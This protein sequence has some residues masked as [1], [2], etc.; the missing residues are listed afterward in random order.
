L[1]NDSAR[2][3]SPE[4]RSLLN[5]LKKFNFF[6]PEWYLAHNMDVLSIGEDPWVHFV[7]YGVSEHRQPNP[8]FDPIWYLEFYDD[9]RNAGVNPLLHYLWNGLHEGR[10]PSN[11]ADPLFNVKNI[12]LLAVEH[13]TNTCQYCSTSSPFSRKLSHSASSF[14]PWLDMLESERIPFIYISITGGEPFLHHDIGAFIYELKGRYPF[15]K[16]GVTTNFYWANE[17]KIRLFAPIIQALDGGLY[18]SLYD[19]LITK[20]GGL[21]RFNSLIILLRDLCPGINIE[22]WN[23]PSFYSWELYKDEREVKDTCITS[24]C[25]ILR[26]DGTISHCSIG[27]GLENRL[28][29]LP[30]M[31][32]SKERLFNLSKGIDG[33]LSWAMK[34]PFDLCSH[35]SMWRKI[36]S[37][38]CMD[39]ERGRIPYDSRV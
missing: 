35:C 34:Y 20:L 39:R 6:D 4:E 32:L 3:L 13:C 8:F 7:R 10:K 22:V 2:Q 24:D 15:K 12:N 16:I 36:T 21:E 37:T 31:N 29:Y 14:F 1:T 28:E 30:V 33:F 11:H 25:Y 23:R 38:W 5:L 19:N 18:I 17:N 9:V 26:A 27:A